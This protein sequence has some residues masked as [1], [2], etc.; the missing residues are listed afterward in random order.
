MFVDFDTLPA[1]ARVWVYQSNR[2][3]NLEEQGEIITFLSD[4]LANWTAH[5]RSL[6]ASAKIMN[7]FFVLI[8]V[9]EGFQ[10]VSGCSIDKQVHCI[11]EIE[12]KWN[13]S[14]LDH[15]QV[16]YL[17]EDGVKLVHFKK[18]KEAISKNNISAE[19]LIFNKN[20]STKKDLES[21]WLLPAQETWLKSYFQNTTAV[22]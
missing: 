4:F 14:L 18:I 21:S 19:T 15:S 3:F 2:P 13:V 5:Q 6:K 16:A 10:A 9:D 20:I 7:N 1:E 17:S 8:G 12:E 11:K 22:V